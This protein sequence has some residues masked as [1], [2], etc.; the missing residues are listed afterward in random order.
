MDDEKQELKSLLLYSQS[1]LNAILRDIN[2]QRYGTACYHIGLLD[3]A[4]QHFL[5]NDG[6][7]D[8]EEEAAAAEKANDE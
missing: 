7:L 5:S 2:A 3:S 6:L 4:V 8:E 1:I